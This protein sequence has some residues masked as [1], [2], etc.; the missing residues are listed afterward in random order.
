M[1]YSVQI[2]RDEPKII[3]DTLLTGTVSALRTILAETTGSRTDLRKISFRDKKMI[4]V[5]DL[6][7]KVST[8]VISDCDSYILQLAVKHFNKDFCKQFG[9]ILENF[10]R[11]INSFYE[12]TN[13]VRR[14]FPFF[15]PEELI[16]D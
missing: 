10:D 4:V 1:L 7:K 12:A 11:A 5:E 14:V 6:E 2:G 9:V 8:I 13:I 16:V 3:E 15:P